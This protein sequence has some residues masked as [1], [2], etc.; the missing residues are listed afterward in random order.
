VINAPV[1]TLKKISW[2]MIFT[3][4]VEIS[5][6]PIILV[7]LKYIKMAPNISKTPIIIAKGSE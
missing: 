2:N 1:F 4:I 3:K 7:L 5:K 6:Q